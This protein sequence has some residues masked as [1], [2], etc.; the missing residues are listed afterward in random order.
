[1]NNERV[2]SAEPAT[3]ANISFFSAVVV[4]QLVPHKFGN[5]CYLFDTGC[6]PCASIWCGKAPKHSCL[7]GAIFPDNHGHLLIAGT[8][9]PIS[10]R[11]IKP[12]GHLWA[13]FMH[14][15]LDK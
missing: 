3:S 2:L 9:F 11:E 14:C 12:C 4:T 5:L 1:M 6:I 13:I 10:P 7:P 15:H 8:L